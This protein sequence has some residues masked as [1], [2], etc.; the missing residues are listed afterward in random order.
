M[1]DDLVQAVVED[2]NN[3]FINI[4]YPFLLGVQNLSYLVCG[5]FYTC[6]EIYVDTFW[7][8]GPNF[9]TK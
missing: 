8:L 5:G 1:L 2:L 4:H 3:T 9:V 7:E 6:I